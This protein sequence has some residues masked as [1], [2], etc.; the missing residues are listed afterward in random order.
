MTRGGFFDKFKTEGLVNLLD[1]KSGVRKLFLVGVMG[2]VVFGLISFVFWFKDYSQNNRRLVD[3]VPDEA[4]G[5]IEFNLADEKLKS[6]LENHQEAKGLLEEYILANQL[7]SNIWRGGAEIERLALVTFKKEIKDG[8][9]YYLDKAWLVQGRKD[10]K[11]L[12]AT[13]LVDYYYAVLNRGVAVLSKSREAMVAIRDHRGADSVRVLSGK[14]KNDLM[15]GYVKSDLYQDELNQIVGLVPLLEDVILSEKGRID[16]RIEL[17]EKNEVAVEVEIPLAEDISWQKRKGSLEKFLVIDRGVIVKN[18]LGGEL[19]KIVEGELTGGGDIDMEAFEIYVSDKYQVEIE[20]LYTFFKQPAW[21]VLKPKRKLNNIRD[22][23]NSNNYFYSLVSKNTF[24]LEKE[25]FLE[26]LETLVQNYLAFKFPETRVKVLP[27]GSKGL[28]LIA[29]ADKFVWQPKGGDKGEVKVIEYENKEVAY[30]WNEGIFILAN[31]VKLV[32]DILAAKEE[33]G[34]NGEFDVKLD[35]NIF[36]S[37][38]LNLVEDVWLKGEVRSGNLLISGKA[39]L[40]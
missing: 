5:Y 25:D 21:L 40:E 30:G 27:D 16:W 31:S 7:P 33:E 35:A 4:V 12:E 14:R 13:G 28:E 1:M 29:P 3:Y 17:N 20:E 18:I 23:L 6:Y 9:G 38:Y 15:Y 8:I 32:E 26:D 37:R 36:K 24:N 34:E 10:I 22:T 39:E 11:Q 2:L 19:L